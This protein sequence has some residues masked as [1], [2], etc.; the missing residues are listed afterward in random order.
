MALEI[1][2]EVDGAD[3]ASL[4]SFHGLDVE[5]EITSRASGRQG[6]PKK[7]VAAVRWTPGVAS[8][9]AGMGKGLHGWIAE[10]L[11][12]GA[13]I[14]GGTVGVSG[15][16]GAPD[17]SLGFSGA[18]LSAIGFPALDGASREPA[19]MSVE[20]A[21]REVRWGGAKPA[22]RPAKPKDWLASNFRVEIGG[23]PC[24]RVARVDA[25]T[26]NCA[27]DGTVTV[28]DIT[29][30]ISRADMAA[31]EEAARRWFIAGE[32]RD[33]HEM[34]GSIALLGPDGKE[35]LA[36]IELGNVGLKRFS[37]VDR[38]GAP[39]ALARFTVELYVE[40]LGLTIADPDA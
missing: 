17:W 8:F 9:G 33:R 31:W 30:A 21:A 34:K 32:H 40:K 26:W 35:A 6:M 20:F 19:L 24:D 13:A 36:T 37:R 2:L 16:P 25:F 14:R 38:G 18:R 27:A 12:T 29:L 1:R 3:V 4:R 22:A 23:L 10:A 15:A 28:P 39:D 5:A 11:D 7:H